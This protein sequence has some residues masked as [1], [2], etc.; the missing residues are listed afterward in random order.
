MAETISKL[1]AIAT[2]LLSI[3]N[4]MADG[5]PS[6]PVERT[7]IAEISRL[8]ELALS[9]QELIQAMNRTDSPDDYFNNVVSLIKVNDL[10]IVFVNGGDGFLVIKERNVI[11]RITSS[12]IIAFRDHP[13]SPS[14][15][16][17]RLEL[18]ENHVKYS[19]P[20]HSFE[21]FGLDG[22]D[23]IYKTS[24]PEEAQ[25]FLPDEVCRQSVTLTSGVV[26][27]QAALNGEFL[28][29]VFSRE[30]GW[31]RPDSPTLEKRCSGLNI[32]R[33]P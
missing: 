21:D 15:G 7:T 33:R 27:C 17:E 18:S 1:L 11:A 10:S 16:T 6:L 20:T 3:S 2:L 19:G 31:Y 5:H 26:C 29:Y 14:V 22:L 25:S 30:Q 13:A 24:S 32:D 28:G 4:V 8:G 12:T 9:E 23:V